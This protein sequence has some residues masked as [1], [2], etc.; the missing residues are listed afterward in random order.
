MRTVTHAVRSAFRPEGTGTVAS[1]GRSAGQAPLVHPNSRGHRTGRRLPGLPQSGQPPVVVRHTAWVAPTSRI[2]NVRVTQG[3][4]QRCHRVA[5]VTLELPGG[6][7]VQAVNRNHEEAVEI[8]AAMR[9]CS[10]KAAVTGTP[11]ALCGLSPRR[12]GGRTGG[13]GLLTSAP[14]SP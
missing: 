13:D 10:V 12:P 2:L 5:H 1:P 6:E 11:I 9:H 8:T 3:P 14:S 4:W 7:D